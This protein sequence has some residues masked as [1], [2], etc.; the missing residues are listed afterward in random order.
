MVVVVVEPPLAA[1]RE[2][3]RGSVR[4]RERVRENPRERRKM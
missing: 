2:T 4:D 3:E 1:E